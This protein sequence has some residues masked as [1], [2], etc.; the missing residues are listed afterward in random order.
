MTNQAHTVSG[1]RIR[2]IPLVLKSSVVTMKFRA[3]MSEAA[4]KM[5]KLITQRFSPMPC[6]GPA[7]SPR[8]LKGA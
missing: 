8:A 7:I 5:N 3:P 1:S 4:Q 6:P 2:L